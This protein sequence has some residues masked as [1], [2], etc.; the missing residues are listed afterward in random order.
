M[1]G[2]W[3]RCCQQNQCVDWVSLIIIFIY[4]MRALKRGRAVTVEKVAM[5]YT[6]PFCGNRMASTLYCWNM[7]LGWRCLCVV[8]FL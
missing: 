8:Y 2:I 5:L 7:A 4:K 6:S 3:I 1:E